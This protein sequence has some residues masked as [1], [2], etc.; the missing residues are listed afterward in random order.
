MDTK[1]LRKQINEMHMSMLN[2]L[3]E[4]EKLTQSPSDILDQDL[5][6]LIVDEDFVVNFQKDET[7]KEVDN[8][9][10]DE[11]GLDIEQTSKDVLAIVMMDN[12]GSMGIFEKYL[13]RCLWERIERLL[14]YKYKNVKIKFI[15]HHTKAKEV[16]KEEFFAKGEL[17]GT[18]CSSA[19]NLANQMVEEFNYIDNDVIVLHISDGDN[20]PAD[21]DRVVNLVEKIARKSKFIGYFEINQYNRHSTMI[22][23]LRDKV[24]NQ[25]FNY[26]VV[27]EKDNIYDALE[28]FCIDIFLK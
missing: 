19:Y 10:I 9:L 15:H 6:K 2:L 12:S 28:E 7:L 3:N 16:N 5:R 23:D 13:G 26:F 8:R 27:A 24:N 11:L 21:M 20:L 14:S 1:S 22:D 17:G 25:N 4:Y 18:I